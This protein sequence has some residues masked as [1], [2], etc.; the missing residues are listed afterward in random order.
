MRRRSTRSPSER[1]GVHCTKPLPT[2]TKNCRAQKSSA[3]VVI[4]SAQDSLLLERLVDGALNFAKRVLWT[5]IDEG[6]E[7]PAPNKNKVT[8]RVDTGASD[9]CIDDCL[10]PGVWDIPTNYEKLKVPRRIVGA[11]G[12]ELRADAQGILWGHITDVEG[13]EHKFG[14]PVLVVPGLTRNI[15][16]VTQALERVVR[17]S[18][19]PRNC[20]LKGNITVQKYQNIIH[21]Y[22]LELFNV[23]LEQGW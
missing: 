5:T 2:V 17:A 8:F 1:L 12:N 22:G 4:G 13:N 18:F 11:G 19:E 20:S 7:T 3:H 23:R 14:T 10:I 21:D 15:Y 6:G 9:T 16:S